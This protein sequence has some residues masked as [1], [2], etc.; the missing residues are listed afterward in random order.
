MKLRKLSEY[1][2]ETYCDRD[3]CIWF[4]TAHCISDPL[5]F[6]LGAKTVRCGRSVL[7]H[8]QE[9]IIDGYIE[10]EFTVLQVCE[11]FALHFVHDFRHFESKVNESVELKW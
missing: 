2:D 9:P 6:Y 3:D 10:D 8:S 4:E 11:I 1:R 7:R 5:K